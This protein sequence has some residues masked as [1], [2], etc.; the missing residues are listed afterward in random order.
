M[1]KL[2]GIDI[3]IDIKQV[4]VRYL[5]HPDEI[6]RWNAL[7]IKHHYLPFNGLH[8]R[9]LRHVAEYQ[10]KWLALLGWQGGAFKL[11]PRDRFIGWS[12]DQQF[13]RL[14]FIAQN[15]RFLVLERIPNLAS[16]VLTLSLKRLSRDMEEVHGHKVFLAETFVDPSRFKGSCYKACGWQSLGYSKGF[17]RIRQPG[18]QVTTWKANHQPKEIFIK[19]L[20]ADATQQ[21]SS[22]SMAA[23]NTATKKNMTDTTLLSLYEHFSQTVD[24]RRA[25]GRRYSMAFM[26]TLV[27]AASLCGYYGVSETILY[28]KALPQHI[29]KK[30]GAC[31]CPL[32]QKYRVPAVSTL[33]DLM[34]KLDPRNL[35]QSL[36]QFIDGHNS[37]TD[38]IAFTDKMIKEKINLNPNPNPSN[39]DIENSCNKASKKVSWSWIFQL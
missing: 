37:D 32:Q 23:Q 20:T 25:H 3:D 2:T 21:L 11:S 22:V 10:D 4:M 6:K 8:G 14:H 29:L 27:G 16:R 26:M 34:A 9:S 31:Y 5:S 36:T 39:L 24:P 18:T 7:M 19:L 15:A 35:H 1:N 30:I 38:A 17:S 12:Q 33:H 28:G 13:S